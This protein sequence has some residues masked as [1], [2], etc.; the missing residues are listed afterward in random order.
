MILSDMYNR[1][2]SWGLK[3]REGMNEREKAGR[4]IAAEEDT[5]NY[6]R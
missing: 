1:K 2:H 4:F 3:K 6:R 5:T